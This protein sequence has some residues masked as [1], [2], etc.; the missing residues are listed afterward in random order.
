[1]LSLIKNELF[2]LFHSKKIYV[3]AII[4][5]ALAILGSITMKKQMPAAEITLHIVPQ[6]MLV[7]VMEAIMVIFSVVLISD[8]I[9]DEYKCGTLKLPMLHPISRLQY[10]A[11][12]VISVVIITVLILLF[13]MVISYILNFIILGT[14]GA[15]DVSEFLNVLKAYILSTLPLLAFDMI[16]FFIAINLSSGGAAI[17]L[18][19]GL[20]F[21]L[22]IAGQIIKGSGKYLIT[23][24][25]T[26][27][28]DK[29]PKDTLIEGLIAIGLYSI[30]FFLISQIIFKRKD[31]LE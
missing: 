5:T 15:L 29:A 13:T 10:F 21:A 19:L 2:K 6:F 27:F 16:I 18:S 7:A 26:L 23:T 25:F 11:S 9:T 14:G 1:M 17:G 4:I 30:V 24:Y 22:E 8:M 3:F 31:I 20:Y 12:K 28:I